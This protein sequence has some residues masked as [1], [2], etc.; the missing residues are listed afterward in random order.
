MRKPAIAL[1]MLLSVA[2]VAHA[3]IGTIDNAP[4]AT[5][6]YPY[7][8]VDLANAA[9]TDTELSLINASSS[10][11]LVKV[12]IWSDHSVP[13]ADFSIYLT[14]YD[15]QTFSMR[16]IL[17]NGVIPVTATDG[18]DPTDGL[19]PQGNLSQDINFASC[20]DVLPPANFSAAEIASMQAAL[21]GQNS[22][23][24]G[25][26][27]GTA[28]GDGIARGYVTMDTVNACTTL[29]PASGAPY[30][31]FLDGRNIFLGDYTIR[32]ATTGRAQANAAVHIEASTTDPLV[33]TSGNYTFY[34][35]YNG[36]TATDRREA[37]PGRWGAAYVR[38]ASSVMA[39]RDSK[40]NPSAFP[41]GS[42]PAPFPMGHRLIISFDSTGEPSGLTEAMSRPFPGETGLVLAGGA[43]LPVNHKM[44]WLYLNL[45]QSA[46]T[47][48]APTADPDARQ[49]FVMMHTLPEAWNGNAP[50]SFGFGAAAFGGPH[51][52][53]DPQVPALRAAPR[54]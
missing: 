36:F 49:A 4:A 13:V 33:I 43:T 23:L 52:G 16:D 53:A 39:W 47:G 19:S 32:N 7:F 24:L 40:T 22:A 27:A 42:P 12:V 41:C 54:K 8:E 51:V 28:Y 10:A 17:V 25:G 9:G 50:L 2:T 11:G 6:L 34:G 26:C 1:A 38:N 35:R 45:N 46:G 29:T 20:Q 31:P 14:G 3:A 44:G 21:T 48:S 18:Q 30:V 5:I 15:M 37:L